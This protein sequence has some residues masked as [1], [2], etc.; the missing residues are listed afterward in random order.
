MRYDTLGGSYYETENIIFPFKA[1]YGNSGKIY[2]FDDLLHYDQFENS[3][4]TLE[5]DLTIDAAYG[6]IMADTKLNPGLSKLSI[7]GGGHSIDLAGVP[8]M[9]DMTDST[10]SGL[11]LISSRVMDSAAIVDDLAPTGTIENC[12]I[13]LTIV[14]DRQYVGGAANESQGRIAGVNFYGSITNDYDEISG[15]GTIKGKAEGCDSICDEGY[16]SIRNE[17]INPQNYD[18]PFES[19]TGTGGIVGRQDVNAT[20]VNGNWQR[21]GETTGV[22]NCYGSGDVTGAF[23][24]GGLVGLAVGDWTNNREFPEHLWSSQYGA[25]NAAYVK[26]YSS[27]SDGNVSAKTENGNG[28]AGGVIGYS[29]MAEIKGSSVSAT[30]TCENNATGPDGSK[31]RAAGISAIYMPSFARHVTMGGD[32]Y[33]EGKGFLMEGAIVDQEGITPEVGRHGTQVTNTVTESFFHNNMPR[34]YYEGGGTNDFFEKTEQAESA[35]SLY[36]LNET[37]NEGTYDSNAVTNVNQQVAATTG[38]TMI[39]NN[40]TSI[41]DGLPIFTTTRVGE[42]TGIDHAFDMAETYTYGDAITP[43]SSTGVVSIEYAAEDGA[44]T[45]SVPVDAGTYT[46]KATFANGST[47]KDRFTIA[48]RTVVLIDPAETTL[49]Y[50]GLQRKVANPYISNLVPG[51]DVTVEATGNVATEVGAYTLEV[52][53]LSGDDAANYQLPSKAYTMDWSI[54]ISDQKADSITLSMNGQTVDQATLYYN[55]DDKKTLALKDITVTVLDEEGRTYCFKDGEAVKRSFSGS[56]A[57]FEDD[58][59]TAEAE[60]KGTLTASFGD[61][62]AE[63]AITSTEYVAVNQIE[64]GDDAAIVYESEAYDLNA[65]PLKAIDDNG[66]AYVLSE[67]E[68]E[69]MTWKVS[70]SQEAVITA[71]IDENNTLTVSDI[72]EARETTIQLEAYLTEKVSCFIELTVRARPVVASIT[73]TPDA[74]ALRPGNSVPLADTF[75][76]SCTDQFDNVIAPGTLTW[77]SS[78]ESIAAIRDGKYLD[79]KADGTAAITVAVNGVTS[80]AVSVT[81][82]SVPQLTSIEITNAPA[83]MAWNETLDLRTL[84]VQQLDQNGQPMPDQ[85]KFQWS[86]EKGATNAAVLGDTLNSGNVKGAITLKASVTPSL[87]G[88]VEIAVGPTVETL[89]VEPTSLSAKGGAVTATLSGKMLSG[90]ISVGL[91]KEGD[92]APVVTAMSSMAGECCQAVLEVPANETEA[93]VTYTA[94][95]SYDGQTYEETPSTTITVAQPSYEPAVTDLTID[96]NTFDSKGGNVTVSL[97]GENLTEAPTVALF[98]G[99]KLIESRTSTE[100]EDGYTGTLK[101][102]ANTSTTDKT[103]TVKVSID[104]ENYLAEPTASLTVSGKSGGST[105]GGGGGGIIIPPLEDDHAVT[106]EKPDNGKI[107]ASDSKAE[108]GDAVTITVTPDDGYV[109]DKVTITDEDGNAIKVTDN[110]DGTFTFTMPDGEV[111]IEATFV[112]EPPVIDL[113]FADVTEDAWYAGPVQFV[114]EQGLMTGVSETDFGPN[115][116]TTRGMIVTMLYRLQGEP[117][118]G[119]GTFSDV[120]ADA[121]YADAVTW[122]AENGIVSGYGSGNFGPNDAITREQL[123]AILYRY[124]EAMRYEISARSDL[125]A[126][127][128]A[129]SISSWATDVISWAHAMGLINGVSK[130]ELAPQATATRAQVAAILERFLTIDW[131]A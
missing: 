106:I 64:Q 14:T 127:S 67:A 126:Y 63:I 15:S 28:I 77:T 30:V 97:K 83:A 6:K 7:D 112:E 88:S 117:E 92:E 85:E 56:C 111:S 34:W 69:G 125:S 5:N 49:E 107:E 89:N 3:Q 42:N 26:I 39:E 131:E 104:G 91:F 113:P 41:N 76:V 31:G 81:V 129:D 8:L 37:K 99:D 60:G 100:G 90:G 29:V 102:P 118:V 38:A 58:V 78:D 122:A 68:R 4:V 54:M 51:D 116:T 120:N 70:D 33:A 22:Y 79:A 105:G 43:T 25:P 130:T 36:W 18:V 82:A 62:K 73:V 24:V 121:Y 2:D 17:E 65:V 9:S 98:D 12:D 94:K 110:G 119:D 114:Y 23:N 96:K 1:V 71:A 55:T 108:T 75:R 47:K 59:L 101:V 115:F 46:A 87:F 86:V 16:S 93:A 13:D 11:A 57:S 95:I 53:G 32:I 103:Y 74:L 27:V 10:V 35:R 21:T 61:L 48:K 72:G 50:T 84:D 128:D 66:N 109:V 45:G 44:F 123:A 20:R 80:N 19:A 124:C 40:N 52:T